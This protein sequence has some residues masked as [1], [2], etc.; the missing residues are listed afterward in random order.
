MTQEEEIAQ[1][2]KERSLVLE[3]VSE[4]GEHLSKAQEREGE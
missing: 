3:R 2:K 1:L 4:M